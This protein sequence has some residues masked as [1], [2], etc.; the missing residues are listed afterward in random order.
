MNDSRFFRSDSR[1]FFILLAAAVGFLYLPLARF[2][3]VQDDWTLIYGY[4]F[5]PA[6][7]T[8][9]DVLSPAGK[10]FF[11]PVGSLYCLAV[12]ALFGLNPIGFHLLATLALYVTAIAVVYLAREATGD[13]VLAWGSGFLYAG[14]ANVHFDPQMWL[15]GI[16]DIGTGLSSVI[17]LLLVLR[18][19]YTLSAAWFA[20]AMAFK[21]SAAMLLLVLLAW[22][23][24]SGE[25]AGPPV[26]VIRMLVARYRWHGIAVGVL[27]AAKAVGAPLYAFATS[28]P[29]AVRVFGRHISNNI[30]LYSLWG[31]QAVVPAKNIALSESASLQV[32]FAAIALIVVVFFSSVRYGRKA[33]LDLLPH[34]QLVLFSAVW[35]LLMLL[36][37]LFLQ[38]HTNQY[39]LTLALPP[40]VIMTMITLKAA[41]V[42]LGLGNRLKVLVYIVFVGANVFDGA[43][44]IQHRISLG[45]LDGV[46]ASNRDGDNHFIRKATW[47]RNV[48]KPL[49]ASVP[50]IPSHSILVLEGVESGSFAEQFGPR[51]WYQDSTIQVTNQVPVGPDSMGLFQV[52][53]PQEDPWNEP[54]KL[55]IVTVPAGQLIHIRYTGGRLERIPID[56]LQ[57]QTGVL[58]NAL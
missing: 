31:L 50:S 22:T 25:L 5:R 54:L 37:S 35:F 48:W 58:P 9:F 20:L 6:S 44:V 38:N 57:R 7:V 33:A 27:A 49:L 12:Y 17:C 45:I 36:P 11:R 56:S 41:L 2:P 13:W 16:Y 1:I 28:H 39:Y 40:L 52:T 42:S 21:E 4:A 47:V 30:Q 26:R 32:L 24:I 53:L 3:F 23:A 34:V 46:H 29:Y 15:V 43:L 10:F 18:K 19:R 14:A 55:N 51:V 8:I